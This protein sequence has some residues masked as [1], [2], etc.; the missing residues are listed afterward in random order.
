MDYYLAV[1]VYTRPCFCAYIDTN[2]ESRILQRHQ[3]LGH[4]QYLF[5]WLV[6]EGRREG[7]EDV[8]DPAGEGRYYDKI[9][10]PRS[11]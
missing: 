3:H 8:C 4:G 2:L 1:I 11:W 9:L 5:Q 6:R 10:L 7:V